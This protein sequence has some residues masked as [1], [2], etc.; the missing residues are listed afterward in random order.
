[1]GLSSMRAAGFSLQ[2]GNYS[3]PT[4]LNLQHTT[5]QEQCD[6]CDNSTA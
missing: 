2:P 4:A 5:E 6:Q 1:M 3:S